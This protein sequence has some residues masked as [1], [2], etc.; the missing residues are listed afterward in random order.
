MKSSDVTAF[1]LPSYLQ[2]QPQGEN[3]PQFSRRQSP[4]EFNTDDGGDLGRGRI[5][6]A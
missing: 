5:R 2:S 6:Y 3:L 4:M 1:Q